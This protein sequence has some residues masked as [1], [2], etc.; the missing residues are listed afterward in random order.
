MMRYASDA[1]YNKYTIMHFIIRLRCQASAIRVV[2][3][4]EIYQKF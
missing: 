2:L 3:E 4:V 1:Q